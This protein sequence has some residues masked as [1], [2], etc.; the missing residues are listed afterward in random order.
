MENG[1]CSKPEML[2][3]KYHAAQIYENIL[4]NNNYEPD[5]NMHDRDQQIQEIHN[6]TS[7]QQNASHA[8]DTTN[9]QYTT[10]QHKPGKPAQQEDTDTK[11]E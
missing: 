3:G 4:N 8:E 7:N 2:A 9:K 11:Q 6:M 10:D 1:D 5:I